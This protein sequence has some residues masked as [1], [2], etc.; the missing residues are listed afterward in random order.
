LRSFG[1]E[2]DGDGQWGGAAREREPQ[3]GCDLK[4]LLGWLGVGSEGC[5][6]DC[7]RA[8]RAA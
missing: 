4:G 8:Q 1:R 3:L 7:V 6:T 5:M 2:E